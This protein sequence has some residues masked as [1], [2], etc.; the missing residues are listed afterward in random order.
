MLQA[1]HHESS[2]FGL[3][4]TSFIPALENSHFWSELS[5]ELTQDLK[6]AGKGRRAQRRHGATVTE[7]APK[8]TPVPLL[9]HSA[10]GPG[11]TFGRGQRRDLATGMDL[12]LL[13]LEAAV[14]HKKQMFICIMSGFNS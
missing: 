3:E 4:T 6:R 10:R 7:Q 12:G 1:D 13:L 14:L 11:G 2:P 8:L 5:P 9:L